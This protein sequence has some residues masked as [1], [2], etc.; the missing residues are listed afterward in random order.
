MNEG[1]YNI[2]YRFQFYK[3]VIDYINFELSEY[4]K[5]LIE[6][7]LVRKDHIRKRDLFKTHYAIYIKYRKEGGE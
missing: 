4:D 6:F 3:Q 1:T 2:L 7:K 5:N